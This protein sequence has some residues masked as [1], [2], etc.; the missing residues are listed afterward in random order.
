MSTV[1]KIR[2]TQNEEPS[3]PD[4]LGQGDEVDDTEIRKAAMEVFHDMVTGDCSL[5][6]A[7]LAVYV[8]GMDKVTGASTKRRKKPS[9]PACPYSAIVD[10]YEKHLDML[11][12]VSDITVARKK[13]LRE[14]WAWILKSKRRDGTRRA[15]TAEQ[16]LTWLDT[17][18]ETAATN[19]FITGKTPRSAGHQNWKADIDYLVSSRGM[20]QVMEKT[21]A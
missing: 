10:L 4:L 16:A 21:H 17:Y 2:E 8:A 7:V 1:V 20:K 18:F 19:D 9:V 11:P 15:E 3:T 12:T 6:D 14:L 13:A 5:A